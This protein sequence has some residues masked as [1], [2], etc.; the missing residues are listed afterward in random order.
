MASFAC[1]FSR[2]ETL[3]A[4]VGSVLVGSKVRLRSILNM[5]LAD[6]LE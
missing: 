5:I 3:D 1:S 6:W 4:P 2:I